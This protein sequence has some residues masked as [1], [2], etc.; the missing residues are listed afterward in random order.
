[1]SSTTKSHGTTTFPT[2]IGR[3]SNYPHGILTLKL[4]S[5]MVFLDGLSLKASCLAIDIGMRLIEAPKSSSSPLELSFPRVTG[6]TKGP[7]A[8]SFLAP[9]PQMMALTCSDKL[10]TSLSS[11]FLFPQESLQVLGIL[12][13]FLHSLQ[14]RDIHFKLPHMLKK[15]KKFGLQLFFHCF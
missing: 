3:S 6:S 14:E 5:W 4:A 13:H 9:V 12:R 7:R 8:F 2:W 15:L 10:T 11:L 1:M